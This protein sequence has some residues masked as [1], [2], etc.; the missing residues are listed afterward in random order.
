MEKNKTL[1]S[2][3]LIMGLWQAGQTDWA[4]IQPSDIEKAITYAI[5][6]GVTMFDTALSYGN[7]ISEK[8]IGE[9]SKRYLPEKICIATK[10]PLN[11]LSNKEMEKACD[12]SLTHLQRDVI[13]VLFVHWPAGM[14]GTPKI[15]VE[16]T[17]EA[18]LQLKQKG[19]IR[20]VG[21]SNFSTEKLLRFHSILPID[22]IQAP[23][24]LFWRI[25]EKESIRYATE[26]NIPVWGYSPLAQGILTG[27]FTNGNM[28]TDHRCRHRLLDKNV[29]PKV[30]H[31]L[32][33]LK[34]IAGRKN[35]SLAQLAL[36]WIY[37][38]KNITPILGVRNQKQLQ[39]GLRAKDI[40]LSDTD[41]KQI[42]LISTEIR[43]N[44][45]NNPIQWHHR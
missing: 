38:Q 5:E 22:V 34:E 31:G 37:H 13:D 33:K 39:E 26:E 28:P 10:V 20:F 14:F 23:Y 32:G 8:I 25:A 1:P 18:F 12:T 41:L 16:E 40:I 6:A 11:A 7:G 15:P 35:V 4:D 2:P 21:C 36:A 44:L 43:R 24:S 27:K 42:D 3:A 45:D 19:K 9:I 17:A 30:E 29:F